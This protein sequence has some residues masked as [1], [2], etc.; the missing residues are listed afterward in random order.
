MIVLLEPGRAPG[1]VS[2][3]YRYQA[4]IARRL[5]ARGEGEL[6]AI[7][8]AALDEAVTFARRRPGDVVVVD[9]LFAEQ[10]RQ[11][12]PSGVVALLHCVPVAQPWSVM[13]LPV[14][15]TS[16]PTAEAVRATARSVAVV[17]PG[18]DR[19]F[20]PGA[21][22]SPDGSLRVVCVGTIS[23]GKNQK[24]VAETMAAIAARGVP[25][26][27]VL[28]GCERT[29]PAYAASVRAAA[30]ALPLRVPGVQPPDRVAAEL[31]CADLLVSASRQESFGMAVAEAVACGVPVLAFATGEIESFVRNGQNGW[32]VPAGST[33]EQ[34]AARLRVLLQDRAGLAEARTS[35]RAVAQRP[36]CWSWDEAAVA[37]AA[38]CHDLGR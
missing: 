29:M 24:L 10:R 6:R 13:P 30:A 32:L 20:A 38:A 27:L 21:A 19:C 7:A 17:R 9:G 31:Q 37:F 22:R 16:S 25:C 1:F 14:I 18:L 26:E 23:P 2:G 8:P 34:F 3:G 36:P 4:E 11:P 12:L 5:A 28:V 35:A 33:D 15:T